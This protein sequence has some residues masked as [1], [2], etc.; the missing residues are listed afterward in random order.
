MKQKESI[1]FLFLQRIFT[2]LSCLII[3]MVVC[4]EVALAIVAYIP[5]Y[6]FTG[7]EA[8]MFY[9]VDWTGEKLRKLKYVQDI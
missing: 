8:P 3:V 9:M 1:G 5:F 4:L 6:F 7:L 2:T